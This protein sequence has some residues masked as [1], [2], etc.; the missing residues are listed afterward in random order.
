MCF[1]SDERIN[2]FVV[3]VLGVFFFVGMVASIFLS[4]TASN[5][6][7]LDSY[8]QGSFKAEVLPV[9]IFFPIMITLV[10]CML[11]LGNLVAY[12]SLAR[13]YGVPRACLL[14]TSP[15]PRDS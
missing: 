14:Y 15:S 11:M 4:D 5:A 2:N 10:F 8:E 3:I 12:V 7:G 6:F 13:I 9:I 1:M